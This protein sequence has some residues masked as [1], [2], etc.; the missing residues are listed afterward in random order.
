MVTLNRKVL[1]ATPAMSYIC[2]LMKLK[3]QRK[4]QHFPQCVCLVNIYIKTYRWVV[5]AQ[6]IML[7]KLFC[8]IN[9]TMT[10][11]TWVKALLQDMNIQCSWS[12]EPGISAMGP[13]V[14]VT[15]LSLTSRHLRTFSRCRQGF[16]QI[17]AGKQAL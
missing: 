7:S 2:K 3:G 8:E 5:A 6:L 15:I 14:W 1:T 12:Y 9:N 4:Y 11:K 10:Q 13:S 16:V 17:Q